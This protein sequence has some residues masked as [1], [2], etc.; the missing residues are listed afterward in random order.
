LSNK[1]YLRSLARIEARL[2][3]LGLNGKI[4]RLSPLKNL[5]AIIAEEIKR[6]SKTIVIVGNDQTLIQSINIIANSAVTMGFIPVGAKNFIAQILG[7]PPEER[8]CDILSARRVTKLD[9]GQINGYYFL[10]QVEAPMENLVVK[11]ENKYTLK[12]L[13]KNYYL[14]IINLHPFTANPQ[15][16]F[17]EVIIEPPKR[18][19]LKNPPLAS[20]LKTNQIELTSPLPVN[21]LLEQQKIIKTP[22][23]ITIAPNKLKIIVGKEREF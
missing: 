3:D 17:L 13:A 4:I 21:V 11:C 2:T 22:L 19:F 10:T 9:L 18:S 15:D 1:K 23:N 12:S 16:G 14:R 6:G 5:E 7:I 20:F 8:A